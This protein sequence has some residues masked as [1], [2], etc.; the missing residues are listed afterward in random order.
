LIGLF[1]VSGF[2]HDLAPANDDGPYRDFSGGGGLRGEL[3]GSAHEMLVF[4]QFGRWET[5][6]H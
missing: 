4:R 2:G 6:F 5:S 1:A 3:K